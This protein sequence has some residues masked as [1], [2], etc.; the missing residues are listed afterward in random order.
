MNAQNLRPSNFNEF[1]GKNEIK[2]VLKVAIKNSIDN[3]SNL[4]HLI[5][6]GPPGIGKTSLASIIANELNRKIHYIQGGLIKQYS[7]FL[8]I[9]SM[10]SENDIIFIDEIHNV[11]YKCFELFY[12][13]L[14]EFVID[15]KIGKELNSQFTRFKVPM[16]TMICSTT[17]L[18]NL[19]QPFIDRF[20]IKIFIDNYDEQEIQQ[21]IT[22]INSKF[23]NNLNEDEIKIISKCSKGTPRIAINIFKRIIDFKNYE[24]DKFNILHTLEKISIFPLGLELID[25]KYLEILKK[26]NQPVGVNHLAQCLYM[27]KKMIED[28]IEPYLLKMNLIVRT[29]I[30]RQLSKDG[31]DYLNNFHK[32]KYT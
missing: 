1:I 32:R 25:I 18:S 16:F 30:G 9:F 6:Y 19:P 31:L 27:D 26:Y 22:S 7:D 29:K 24:K 21:I 3:N 13:L 28:K 23:G 10:I 12:S 14:E 2:H 11:D 17:K 4:D 5:F 15:I 8:D 20:P